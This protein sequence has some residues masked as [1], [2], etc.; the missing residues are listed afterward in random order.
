MHELPIVKNMVDKCICNALR[1]DA[2]R[3]KTINLNI[4]C[5]CDI[6][7]KWLGYYFKYLSKGTIAENASLK[8]NKIPLEF[9]CNTCKM[10]FSTLSII[11][12]VKCFNCSGNDCVLINNK[13][14]F[15]IDNMEII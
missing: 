8:I 1:H 14:K 10:Q 6:E 9:Y 15:S 12:G 11:K 4:S 3:I 2:K 7:E 13:N 5:V